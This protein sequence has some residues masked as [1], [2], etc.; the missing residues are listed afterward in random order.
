[1]ISRFVALAFIFLA[2]TIFAADNARSTPKSRYREALRN[3]RQAIDARRNDSPERA[4]EIENFLAR[5]EARAFHRHLSVRTKIYEKATQIL[6]LEG[7][8]LRL[9]NSVKD[10]RGYIGGK[11]IAFKTGETTATL[12]FHIFQKKPYMKAYDWAL[13]FGPED[14]FTYDDEDY[15]LVRFAYIENLEGHPATT[16][17]RALFHIV[18]KELKEILPLHNFILEGKPQFEKGKLV[19]EGRDGLSYKVKYVVDL[20]DFTICREESLVSNDFRLEY[21]DIV[22]M[23]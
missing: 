12:P 16:E 1:M 9:W 15:I 5:Y 7:S 14:V 18:K 6:K 2:S 21:G 19:L 17:E 22:P 4:K 10:A 8:A 23:K 3:Y 11:E 20:Y 13:S